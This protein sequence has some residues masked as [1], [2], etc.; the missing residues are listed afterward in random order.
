MIYTVYLPN[1]Q[2]TKVVNAED[3]QSQL[4]VNE[5]YILGEYPDNKF[6]ISNNTAIELPEQPS[7][8]HI[9]NYTTKTWEDTRS[10]AQKYTD[11]AQPIIQKRNQLLA[12]SDWT[13][14]PDVPLTTKESWAVY[15]QAL[16]DITLQTGYPSNV[17]WPI[18]PQ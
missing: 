6:Y 13:Q 4:S 1:G 8:F 16:R 18:P 7:I 10:L 9:F 3:I 11:A 5:S 12:A 2:I 15:R 17:V 14:L